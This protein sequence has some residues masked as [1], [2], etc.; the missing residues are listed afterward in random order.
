MT[1]SLAFL[2]VAAIAAAPLAAE[3]VSTSR[4]VQTAD[5]DLSTAAGVRALDHR[6]TIAIVDACGEASD[7]DLDGANAVRACRAEAR[8]RVDGERDRILALR[9]QAPVAVASR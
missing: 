5:L 6:L 7:L 1:R 3:P 9:S 8:A 4:S 2:F